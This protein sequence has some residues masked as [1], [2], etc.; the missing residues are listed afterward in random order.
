MKTGVDGCE[1][2]NTAGGHYLTNRSIVDDL[3]VQEA[4]II[5]INMTDTQPL[6]LNE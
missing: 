5:V 4:L 6:K 2:A 3:D 1:V